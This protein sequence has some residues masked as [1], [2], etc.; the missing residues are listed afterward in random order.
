MGQR[1]NFATVK[2][3]Q[4]L[5]RMEECASGMGQRSKYAAVKVAQIMLRQEECASDMGQRSNYAAVKEAQIKSTV[6]NNCVARM[7]FSADAD[8]ARKYDWCAMFQMYFEPKCISTQEVGKKGNLV[9][10]SRPV[11]CLQ[12][13]LGR[14]HMHLGSKSIWDI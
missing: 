13:A 8:S 14:S 9:Y 1:S 5:L 7:I 11:C 12:N 3:A 10:E 4:N 2:G 6:L